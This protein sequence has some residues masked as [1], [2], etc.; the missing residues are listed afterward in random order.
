LQF[1]VDAI[2]YNYN[3]YINRGT[4]IV[5]ARE[6]R[7]LNLLLMWFADVPDGWQT[8]YEMHLAYM[9]AVAIVGGATTTQA[10]VTALFDLL[11][12]VRCEIFADARK[13]KAQQRRAAGNSVVAIS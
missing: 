3:L 10:E 1:Y 7:Y 4:I 5:G 12:L 2:T 9:R 8:E 6:V 13:V 11:F